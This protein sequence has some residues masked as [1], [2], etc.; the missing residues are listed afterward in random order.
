MADSLAGRVMTNRNRHRRFG[1]IRKRDSGRY[2]VR[3]PGPDGRMRT[4]SVTYER[5]ADAERALSLIE[6][7]MISGEWADS[8][9]SKIK[10]QDYA[11]YWLA[12]RPGLRPRTIDLYAWLCRKHINPY[13]GGV[14]L[15]RLSTPM[16][17][18]WRAG[19]LRSGV[20]VSMAAKAYRLLRS[21]LATAVEEDKILARNPCRVR[22]AGTER[23][24]E[25]PVL[26]IAQVFELAE[27][28]GRRPVGNIRQLPAG[29]YRI[30]YGRH[31]VM[32]TWP[33]VYPTRPAAEAALWAM[34]QDGRADSDYDRRYRALVLLATFAS[35][36]WG[37]VTALRRCD[38]DLATGTVR[39]HSAFAERSTGELVLG[40][41][42]SRAS[43]RIVGIPRSIAP[44]LHEH[45]SVFVAPE[46][47]ALAF[48][49]AKGGPLRRSNFNKMSVWPHAVRAVGAQGL[50]FH[51]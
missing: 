20:S 4:G 7:Q 15:G 10:L 42:K 36:R 43:R 22:G 2:Q 17:R 21:V 23:A 32:R 9:R 48:P 47:D 34:A 26:T 1:N 11:T 30:R 31:G 38:L 8:D 39:V 44:V 46:P 14:P 49:G 45:L 50:H 41:P 25:R 13:L 19:L 12:Q 27:L 24:P 33:E 40:A 29:G 51:D 16:I 37:E 35:L 28:V 6:A 18:E 3:Y 5:K